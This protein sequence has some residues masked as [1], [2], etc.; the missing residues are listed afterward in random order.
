MCEMII[1]KVMWE[2]KAYCGLQ[3]EQGRGR[4]TTS[5]S[6]RWRNFMRSGFKLVIEGLAYCQLTRI[7]N[8][9]FYLEKVASEMAQSLFGE[10]GVVHFG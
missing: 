4:E 2:K 8:R 6:D 7:R 10:H 9:P 1:R 3:L 5:V